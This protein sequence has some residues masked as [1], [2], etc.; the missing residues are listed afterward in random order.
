LGWGRWA[1]NFRSYY[2]D[3]EGLGDC[4]AA[5]FIAEEA[6]GLGDKRSGNNKSVDLGTLLVTF[7]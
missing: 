1:I 3:A 7:I 2:C 6:D 5:V 4:G